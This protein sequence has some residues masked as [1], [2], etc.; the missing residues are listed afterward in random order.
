MSEAES[1]GPEPVEVDENEVSALLYTSGTTGR[2][3]GVMLTH[4]NLY[5]E[6]PSTL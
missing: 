6:R 4:R 2:P 5:F 3:K 1:E